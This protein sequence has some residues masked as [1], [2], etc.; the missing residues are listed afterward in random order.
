MTSR[1]EPG[2]TAAQ[3]IRIIFSLSFR[4][5]QVEPCHTMK[6]QK[7]QTSLRALV[8]L[9]ACSGAV[10]WVWRH[11]AESKSDNTTKSWIRTL[12]SGNLD[13]RRYV[14]RTLELGNPD[15]VD[16]V[17][18]ATTEA[19]K[20]KDAPVR[21][22]AALALTRFATST[23]GKYSSADVDRAR[24]ISTTL[25]DAY[26]KDQ[27]VAV[28]AAAA[29]GL[30]SI[31]R[32]LI[33]AR[34]LPKD[35][36]E[37][38]PLKVEVLVAEFDQGLQRDPANRLPLVA[39]VKGLGPL[40][41]AAPPGLLGVLDD[42]SAMVRGEALAALSHFSGGVDRAIPVLL[43]DLKTNTD[44]FQPDYGSIAEGLRPSPDVVPTLIRAL[45]SDDGLV[46]EAA[47]TLLARVQPAPTS[48]APVL[49]AAVKKAISS[50]EPAER[51]GSRTGAAAPGALGPRGG[52]RP[53][54]PP[55]GAVSMDLAIA[56]AKSASPGEAIPLLVE[57]LK[58]KGPESRV[59]GAAGLAEIG[60]AAHAAIPVLVANMKEA[61]SKERRAYD[62]GSQTA[63]AL[64]Q[65]APNSPKAKE[66]SPEV[67]AVL[68]QALKV[69]SIPLRLPSI[70]ALGNFGPEAVAAIP[71][72]RE[73]EN[74]QD[75][76]VREAVE[77]AL[78]KIDLESKPTKTSKL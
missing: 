64:G 52:G 55:P 70:K 2:K 49:I 67:I 41:M 23:A 47:A 68:T 6:N 1:Y 7:L 69:R 15:E 40:P 34:V 17:V 35:L 78:Q 62:V 29:T 63:V 26:R 56:M 27:D 43:N 14:L 61:I 28:R 60:P 12:D 39:A 71:S 11:A 25:L 18:T 5:L 37:T 31:S 19:L 4:T 24:G 30:S 20:D 45:E 32:G 36:A 10:F 9:V 53:E 58:R 57:L 66:T 13:D 59:A 42:P 8:V 33:K 72:L 48:V 65:I 21:V 75:E 16:M 77:K 38:D 22:E 3:F 74:E 51:R 50:G 46:R 76:P 73:L 44:R 54:P